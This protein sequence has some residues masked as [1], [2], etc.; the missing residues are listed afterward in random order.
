MSYPQQKSVRNR[1][2]AGLS[3]DDFAALAPHLEPVELALRQP[4][5]EPNQPIEHLYFPEA[6]FTSIT[7]NG[8]GAKIEIGMV[9]R[10]GFTGVPVA[11]GCDRIPFECFVQLAG[12]AFRIA[13][14][15]IE[16]A[17]D[18]S[19]SLHRSLLRHV[20]ALNVQTSATAFANAEHT[21]EM[22]LARW[23][24]MCH[25]RADADEFNITHEFMSMMLGVRRAG[26]TTTIHILEGNGLIRAKRGVITVRNRDGLKELADDAYG[27]P[28]AEYDRLM[29]AG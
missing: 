12:H 14:P 20:Q 17:M 19:R 28:E 4:L 10:E 18:D 9:G 3:P 11:L 24:L 1:I 25:D 27:L 26:V 5:S 23:L 6:G 21:V 22:R 7:T 16:Q 15:R 2:L 13:T 8:H 29:A